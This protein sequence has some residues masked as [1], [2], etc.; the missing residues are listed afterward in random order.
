MNKDGNI[1]VY[2]DGDW[3]EVD[4]NI[5]YDCQSILESIPI[6]EIQRFLRKKKLEEIKKK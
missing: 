1:L 5:M 6:E 2:N 3:L 4:Q